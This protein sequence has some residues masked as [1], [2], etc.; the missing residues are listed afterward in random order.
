MQQKTLLIILTVIAAIILAVVVSYFVF[1][2]SFGVE[3]AEKYYNQGDKHFKQQEYTEAIADF[4]KSL[5][6]NG[7]SE[8]KIKAYLGLGEI[9]ELKS[10]YTEAENNYR[11]AI[12]TNEKDQSA[13]LALMNL[14]LKFG[15]YQ[16]I[17]NEHDTLTD[18]D[19]GKLIL[20]RAYIIQES[21]EKGSEILGDQGDE[22]L[23]LQGLIRLAQEKPLEAKDL[24]NQARSRV[25]QNLQTK[26]DQALKEIKKLESEKNKA[27][28]FALVG[29]LC[30]DLNEPEFALRSFNEA[31]NT[32][33]DYRDA[34]VGMGYA[35]LKRMRYDLAEKSL[36]TALK[37]DSI[38]SVTEY[39]LGKVYF[40]QNK[41]KEAIK[42]F[43]RAERK[44]YK[45]DN[46]YFDLAQSYQEQENYKKAVSN[47][48][49]AIKI[50]PNHKSSYLQAVYLYLFKLDQIENT[51]K[52]IAP[53][54]ERDCTECSAATLEGMI[55]VKKDQL[56][57][58]EDKIKTALK[59]QDDFAYTYYVEALLYKEKGE[60]DKAKESYTRAVD[61]D[62][63]GE[64]NDWERIE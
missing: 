11:E 38:Y 58:A 5:S 26:I 16:E 29:K 8:T 60:M 41:F 25:D 22:A 28:Y 63:K 46:L 50:N 27:Y 20:A 2:R 48:K 37:Y 51:E 47:Y 64:L 9:Y 15:R 45:K 24:L 10:Q 4:E 44:G 17:V 54:V 35:Y 13:I 49:K 21:L 23:Y 31:L 12:D 61:L 34:W 40:D 43:N 39:L 1:G 52:L 55:F 53:L 57:E 62:L 14:N 36:R 18:S 56:K 19:Q 3:T 7:N 30:N 32:L 33:P 59:S 42:V 6:L